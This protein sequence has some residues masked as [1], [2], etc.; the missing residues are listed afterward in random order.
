MQLL[1]EPPALVIEIG[2]RLPNGGEHGRR[3]AQ[4]GARAIGS[5]QQEIEQRV[6]IDREP[7][8]QLHRLRIVSPRLRLDPATERYSDVRQPFIGH[9]SPYTPFSTPFP[10]PPTCEAGRHP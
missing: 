9:S 4:R 5:V 10:L 8:L 3:I 7:W 1:F 6:T 2:I